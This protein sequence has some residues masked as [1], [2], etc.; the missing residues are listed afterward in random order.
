MVAALA[1][2]WLGMQDGLILAGIQVSPLPLRLVVVQL[3]RRT[4]FR[5][6]PIDHLM[7]CQA[8]VDLPHFQ[9]QFHRVHVPGGLD[10]ENAPIKLTILHS[11]NSRTPPSEAAAVPL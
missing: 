6:R 3:A 1:S 7:V 5:A 10:S 8:N 2:R 11:R 4:A 9:L